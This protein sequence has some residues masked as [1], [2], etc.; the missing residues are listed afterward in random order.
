MSSLYGKVRERVRM[1]AYA[2]K[3][4]CYRAAGVRIYCDGTR[5]W[6]RLYWF[7]KRTASW[8]ISRPFVKQDSLLG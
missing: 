8:H 5:R 3:H 6:F 4:A 1:V 2:M 7:P